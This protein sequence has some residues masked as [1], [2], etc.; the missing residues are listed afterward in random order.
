MAS[1]SAVL[2]ALATIGIESISRVQADGVATVESVQAEVDALQS[3]LD[4]I[5]FPS[6]FE[7]LAGAFKGQA[8]LFGGKSA[9]DAKNDI[10]KFPDLTKDESTTSFTACGG[11]AADGLPFVKGIQAKAGDTALTAIGDMTG[12]SCKT[13]IF[14][15]SGNL[16]VN[17]KVHYTSQRINSIRFSQQ[18]TLVD[19]A[20]SEEA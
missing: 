14:A 4:D 2:W 12:D 5:L 19:F 13:W 3:R 11:T 1:R 15:D 6:F 16:A 7:D 17:F 20:G 10:Y 18:G 8:V 9:T